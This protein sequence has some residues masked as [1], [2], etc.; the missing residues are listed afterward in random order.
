MNRLNR[1]ARPG[2]VVALVVAIT[3]P[4]WAAGDQI[5]PLPPDQSVAGMTLSEWAAAFSQWSFSLPVSSSP[6]TDKTGLRAGVGQR[7]P[8]W[9][10]P[11][12]P[13]GSTGTR[14]ILVPAGDAVLWIG[15]ASFGFDA[16]GHS[17]EAKLRAGLAN[18]DSSYLGSLKNFAV[19]I[20]GAS[21][22][23]L[24]QY[25]VQTPLFTVVLSPSNQFNSAVSAGQDNRVVG[26]ADGYFALL[27]PLPVGRHVLH[28]H[29]EG[30]DPDTKKTFTDDYTVNLVVQEPNVALP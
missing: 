26:L 8:V 30:F 13:T 15:P 28:V 24:Q 18:Y 5:Q 1:W 7:D 17:T 6:S 27:P 21:F 10:I 22:P 19:T 23:D 3:V 2:S 29:D 11:G 16:P 20:D 14:T 12:L 25:R 4:S 9:F